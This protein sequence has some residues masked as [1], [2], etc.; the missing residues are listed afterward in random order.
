MFLHKIYDQIAHSVW[1]STFSGVLLR[2]IDLS[3][4]CGGTKRPL[5]SSQV[6]LSTF[7]P[8]KI[9]FSSLPRLNKVSGDAVRS[10]GST[11][12][13]AKSWFQTLSD[14]SPCTFLG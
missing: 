1:L 8:K 14:L 12:D 2:H 11:S 4:S 5:R 3:E 10:P 7:A 9:K 6:D 13:S